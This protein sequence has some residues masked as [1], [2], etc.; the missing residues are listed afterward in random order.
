MKGLSQRLS[1]LVI[2]MDLISIEGELHTMR[3]AHFF[4]LYLYRFFEA[5]VLSY[6]FVVILV[7]VS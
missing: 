6:M 7:L 3:V 2:F 1:N 4:N 5:A